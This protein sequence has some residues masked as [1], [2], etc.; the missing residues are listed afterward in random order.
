M[1]LIAL[2]VVVWLPFH[3]QP[4]EAQD[5][6]CPP[7][8]VLPFAFS[9]AIYN[10]HPELFG[11]TALVAFS[12]FLT[13]T[14]PLEPGDPS[15][16]LYGPDGRAGAQL[17]SDSTGIRTRR[18]AG[19]VVENAT[20][21]NKRICTALAIGRGTVSVLLAVVGR[22]IS[23][24]PVVCYPAWD[25]RKSVGGCNDTAASSRY[26]FGVK[27]HADYHDWVCEHVTPWLTSAELPLQKLVAVVGF[28][29]LF[30]AFLLG[31]LFFVATS[32]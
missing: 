29:A 18:G 17:R 9:Y 27:G 10:P 1:W 15:Y 30:G 19:D 26:I 13:G 2:A 23:P 4:V 28:R 25:G 21:T 16:T 20:G 12:I 11:M 8:S 7:R 14:T 32:R 24:G 6:A 22:A 31:L 5:N 3:G